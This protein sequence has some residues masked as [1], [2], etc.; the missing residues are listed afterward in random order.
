M[1]IKTYELS[2]LT[3]AQD[4]ESQPNADLE[5]KAKSLARKLT[6]GGLT[7][8]ALA[9]TV[10]SQEVKEKPAEQKKPDA[11]AP[12]NEEVK[13]AASE[14]A[15]DPQAGVSKEEDQRVLK[16][17][18]DLQMPQ[19]QEL[20]LVYEKLRNSDMVTAVA[21][22]I[23]K[24]DPNNKGAQEAMSGDSIDVVR[25]PGYIAEQMKKLYAGQRVDDPDTVAN[26]ADT[27]MERGDAAGAARALKALKRIQYPGAP[28]PHEQ[29]LGY[30]L[31]ATN[32]FDG[33]RAIFNRLSQSADPKVRQDA[34]Q[35]LRDLDLTELLNRGLAAVQAK[36]SGAA[37]EI[38]DQLMAK[39]PNDPDSV[40]FRAAALALAGDHL[41]AAAEL[42]ELKRKSYRGQAFPYQEAL[43][44]AYYEGGMIEKGEA[45]FEEMLAR[46]Y[47]GAQQAAGRKAL[48]DMKRDQS[49]KK[50]Y[51][52]LL[53]GDKKIAAQMAGELDAAH[54]NNPDV[55]ILLAEV[56]MR[57][58]EEDKAIQIL[59][60]LKQTQ[61][62]EGPFPGQTNLAEAHYR[63][64]SWKEAQSAYQEVLTQPGY[65]PIDIKEAAERNQTL[66][67]LVSGSASLLA[68]FQSEEEGDLWSTAA[69]IES[70]LYDGWRVRV[71]LLHEDVSLTQDRLIE[72]D[73]GDRSQA[74]VTFQKML[75]HGYFGEISVGGSEDDVMG[76]V[77][78]G[79]HSNLGI[80]WTLRAELNA[81][82]D[83]SLSLIALD[84]R[85]HKISFAWEVP[86]TDRMYFAGEAYAH[87]IEIGG[88]QHGARLGRQ[89]RTRLRAA[90]R[91]REGS[92]GHAF[93][94]RQRPAVRPQ[95]RQ[96]AA[97]GRSAP[98]PTGRSAGT[99]RHPDRPARQQAW[100]PAHRVE[101]GHREAASL[102]LWRHPL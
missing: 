7:L 80:G 51:T 75:A 46:P 9:S 97:G 91:N 61:F 6:A 66:T 56:K 36:D 38:A 33:A 94:R 65:E 50:A 24:R 1:T 95:R 100:R 84:G 42:D 25:S 89:L 39:A 28:F 74:V 40:G 99:P 78:F 93:L 27:L 23:L 45:A 41:R 22:E 63:Y 96:P 30:A 62:P 69:R 60:Q 57:Q 47:S 88:L 43:A 87:Q 26:Y 11:A 79:K 12:A 34:E 76:G 32:D 13:P 35:Q 2:G 3:S 54:P 92:I 71:D 5:R 85:E 10:G 72:P 70:P 18:P 73:G 64:G 77:A 19:L 59:T 21:G 86:V 101:E 44:Y 14:A 20:L 31:L 67:D 68:R 49:I 102:R 15:A 82:A 48:A 29:D 4:A 55:Q 53:R 52:A 58:Y 8:A 17:L 37:M 81:P 16:S 83:D 98:R 90:P